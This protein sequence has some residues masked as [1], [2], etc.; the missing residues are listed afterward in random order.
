MVLALSVLLCYVPSLF[1]IEQNR[2]VCQDSVFL[3]CG[4]SG[5]EVNTVSRQVFDG[6]DAPERPT[7]FAWRKQVAG[8]SALTVDWIR[9]GL[10]RTGKT[11]SGLAKA[12]GRSPSAV[13]DLLNGHRRLRA[14]E[15]ATVSDYLGIEPPRLIGGGPPRP[16]SAPLIGYV[17]AGAVAHFYADGQGPFDDVDAPLDSKPMTVAVQ[18]RGHSL[19]VLFDNWL[20]FYD[21][22][23]NPPDDSLVG[24][25]CV[26]GL[27]D[28]RVLIKSL[29]RSP[30][31]GLWNLLSNTEP[32][33]YDAGLDWAAPVREMRP[34]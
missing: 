5:N 25:M 12:L 6:R 16:P 9:A 4:F 13:T 32:P 17:G 30:H 8:A 33:I 20:V 28:G 23:H 19:G 29:K 18:I 15:I 2:T 27:S 7:P 14:D 31:T 22:I 21:D 11:R 26:C 10:K 34:R 3:N 24:R 1:T